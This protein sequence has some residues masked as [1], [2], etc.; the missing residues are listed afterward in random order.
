MLK[1]TGASYMVKGMRKAN[2]SHNSCVDNVSNICHQ[3]K[4]K[5][6][7]TII[8]LPLILQIKI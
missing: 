2:L 7:V 6:A 5:I 8:T 1:V 3:K 4:I